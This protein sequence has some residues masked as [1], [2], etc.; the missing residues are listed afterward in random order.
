MKNIDEREYKK[1]IGLYKALNLKKSFE[2]LY[3]TKR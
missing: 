1:T 3:V 2:P